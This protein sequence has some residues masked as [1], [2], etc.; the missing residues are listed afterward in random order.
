MRRMEEAA[1]RYLMSSGHCRRVKETRNPL[2]D[3][4]YKQSLPGTFFS[5]YRYVMSKQ[6]FNKVKPTQTGGLREP[7]E[8][9]GASHWLIKI[10]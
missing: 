4:M 7:H 10:P 6:T 1:E 8:N 2:M 3:I 5:S 9:M